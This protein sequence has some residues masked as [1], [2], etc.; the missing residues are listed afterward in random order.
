[1]AEY[2][3]RMATTAVVERGGLSIRIGKEAIESF[4]NQ[5]NGD[6]SL[7][8]TIDHDPL[9]MPLGKARDAWV[10]PFGDE[11]A[12]MARIHVS[13]ARSAIHMK[14]RSE[15]V[16][17]DFVDEPRPF[18]QCVKDASQSR[19]T[20]G[21][22]LANFDNPQNHATFVD[23]VKHIDDEIACETIGRHSVEPEPLI[24]LVLSHPE[25]CAALGIGLWT[26]RRVE[27]FVRY[28]IDETSRKLGDECS[29]LLSFKIKKIVGAYKNQRS[30]DRRVLT[31]IVVPGETN[32]VLLV[33]IAH[34][35]E[36]PA[37]S[38]EKLTAEMEK[39]GDL[40][41]QA[42]EATFART[43]AGEWEF[44]YLT[45]RT[46]QVLGSVKCHKRTMD[47]L[48]RISRIPKTEGR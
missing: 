40:L 1:M 42:E 37:I 30:D 27:K 41:R 2:I 39:Y 23:A 35:E 16:H 15:L 22:D 48:R 12:V 11:Y 21:V 44:Q 5:L 7:A 29:E 20:V 4:A 33:E 25:I 19:V 32:L 6:R 45:T 31:E 26:F 18:I 43:E 8:L 38:L 14:S 46:G 13:D 34:D 47:K 3:A 36:F 24:K 17:L 28:T 9:C 10:E